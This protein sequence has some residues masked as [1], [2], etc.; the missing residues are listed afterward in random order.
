MPKEI[1]K[2]NKIVDIEKD[3]KS[4]VF[5]ESEKNE[6]EHEQFSRDI[7]TLDNK[8][9]NIQLTPGEKGERGEQGIKGDK[10]EAGRD[11]KDGLDGKDGKDGKQGLQGKIGLTGAKGDKGDKGDKGERGKEGKPGKDAKSDFNM[12]SR[13]TY[14][15][16]KKDGALLTTGEEKSTLRVLV[17]KLLNMK[18]V[19]LRLK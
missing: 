16:V 18:V 2:I 11:G 9:E 5:D 4:F 1:D 12:F 8:I 19:R 17:L 6:T 13:A 10:G 14:P 3:V 7:S 15:A